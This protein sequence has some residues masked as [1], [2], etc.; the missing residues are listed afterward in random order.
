MPL[1]ESSVPDP[2]LFVQRSGGGKVS[3]FGL[4]FFL[5]GIGVIVLAFIPPEIRNG[6]P[7]PL[8][9]AIP[10]G[11]VFLCV[12]G[13]II[14]GRQT[15]QIDRRA[16]HVEKNWGLLDKTLRS[17]RRDLKDFDRISLRSEIRR[18]DKST[19]TVYPIR[20]QGP[21]S[22]DFTLSEPRKESDARRDTEALAKFLGFPIHDESAGT[23]RIRDPDTLDRN[24]KEKFAMGA[25]D[26]AIPDPPA[27]LAS[28]IDYDGASLRVRA[29]APGFKAPVA[30]AIAAFAFFEIF[31]LSFFAIPFFSRSEAEGIPVFVFAIFCF[32]FLGFP[33]LVVLF[34]L[35][36]ALGT[37]SLS[38]TN[39][40]L[41]IENGWLFKRRESISCDEIEECLIGVPG[42]SRAGKAGSLF[43]PKPEMIAVSDDKRISFGSGLDQA[44]LEY[45][46]AL[47]KGV[48]VS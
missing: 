36:R 47:A 18:S 30:L 38:V 46:I 31:F 44:E 11:G 40:R 10:F 8:Y 13:A 17:K 23:L 19:Y 28:R 12:G 32:V 9:V 35:N 42:S 43:G 24:L 20:L 22:E 3:L 14:F 39:Q 1:P 2:D 29:P 33:T 16:G 15:L 27:T 34:I 6:D 41:E 4:P 48:L 37:Q 26:N 7:F 45:V 5:V 21:D 25:E